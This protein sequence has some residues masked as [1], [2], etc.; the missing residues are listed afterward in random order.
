[1]LVDELEKDLVNVDGVEIGE[2]GFR[3][4]VTS[5]VLVAKDTRTIISMPYQ[6][7]VTDVSINF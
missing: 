3:N 1:M 6:Q 5:F 4:T 7:R 2:E